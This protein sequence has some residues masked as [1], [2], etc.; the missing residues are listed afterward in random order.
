V[1]STDT[2]YI[3]AN[4]SPEPELER[5]RLLESVFDDD[6]QR[7]LSA[8]S[9]SLTARTCLEVGAGAGS[10]A[11][12]LASEVGPAGKVV[13][14]DPDTRFLGGLPANVE[15][16]Q[17]RLGAVALPA[18][19]FDIVHAR[20]VLI[21]NPDARAVLRDM[22]AALSPGGTLVLE[23]PDFSAVVALAG[24]TTL[25]QSFSNVCEAIHCTFADR[26]MSWELGRELPEMV[27]EMGTTLDA[28]EYDAPVV[29]GG[30]PLAQM[31]HRSTVALRDKYLAT[32]KATATDLANYATFAGSSACWGIY[33]ATVRVRVSAK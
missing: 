8:A 24:P 6:T 27:C 14:I 18:A 19:E 23:E 13:A 2:G 32:G 3:F 30:S 4:T 25:K 20:Y 26:G 17:G 28:V 12:W 33:Y 16:V 9:G 31:M 5:L 15:V 7:W 21:H 1:K 29:N 11:T 22:L 10:I